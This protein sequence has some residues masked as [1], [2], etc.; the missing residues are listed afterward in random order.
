MNLLERIDQLQAGRND[1]YTGVKEKQGLRDKLNDEM[2]AFLKRG[3]KI[4][5]IPVGYSV[6]S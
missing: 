6:G 2:E 3:G 5:Q 4:K 1:V